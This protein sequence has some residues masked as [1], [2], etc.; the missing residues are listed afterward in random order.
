[1]GWRVSRN[2]FPFG[3]RT[4]KN[5]IYTRTQ[6]KHNTVAKFKELL[7]EAVGGVV[8]TPAIN[9]GSAVANGRKGNATRSGDSRVDTRGEF[10]FRADEL[11]GNDSVDT[12]SD[13]EKKANPREAFAEED[14][15]PPS[16]VLHED[17]GGSVTLRNLGGS[18]DVVVRAG[19]QEKVFELDEEAAQEVRDFFA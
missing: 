12:K 16:V 17:D 18:Y 11:P 8:S 13:F 6:T 15:G 7:Q 1:M 4:I 3:K 19:S 14:Q 2:W 5:A 9:S 10:T